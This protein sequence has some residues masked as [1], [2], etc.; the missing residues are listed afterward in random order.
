MWRKEYP[1]RLSGPALWRR[2]ESNPGEADG[3]QTGAR[4]HTQTHTNTHQSANREVWKASSRK[5]GYSFN[6]SAFE[7]KNVFFLSRVLCLVFIVFFCLF[8]C[9]SSFLQ[10]LNGAL[11]FPLDSQGLERSEARLH[12]T[13]PGSLRRRRRA[14]RRLAPHHQLTCAHAERTARSHTTGLNLFSRG[15]HM[16]SG[17]G[18]HSFTSIHGYELNH[19]CNFMVT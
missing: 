17:G 9:I 8:L 13:F 12:A 11:R 5:Q 3:W 19:L 10:L 14:E 18:S 2:Q 1:P 15:L 6:C 16:E 4:G 7:P